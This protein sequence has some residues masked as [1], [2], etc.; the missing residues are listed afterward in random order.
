MQTT[1]NNMKIPNE[2]KD[3]S[4]EDAFNF[5]KIMNDF[6]L[7]NHESENFNGDRI[8]NFSS[9]RIILLNS[10]IKDEY[11]LDTEYLTDLNHLSVNC[12]IMFKCGNMNNTKSQLRVIQFNKETNTLDADPVGNFGYKL[13]RPDLFLCMLEKYYK[14]EKESL[15]LN[16]TLPNIKDLDEYL[17]EVESVENFCLEV[18][19][20]DDKKLVDELLLIGNKPLNT[21]Q[22]VF[23]YICIAVKF[24]NCRINYIN[25]N[26]LEPENKFNLIVLNEVIKKRNLSNEITTNLKV[27]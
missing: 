20:L 21:A 1:H 3:D 10:I 4:N 5:Y 8:F 11:T 19:N 13:D 12:S 9:D 25:D 14:G 22:N 15:F 6:H 23:D 24:W 17:N 16:S 26:F 18:Y 2:L 7:Q 27:E